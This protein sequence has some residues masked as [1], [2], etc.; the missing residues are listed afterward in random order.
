MQSQGFAYVNSDEVE[1]PILVSSRNLNHAM[2]GDK[3]SVRLFAARKKHDLEGEIIEITE[4]A[5]SVFVGTVQT[6][7]NF[8]F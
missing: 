7:R 8:A 3:V 2:A 5:K 1:R 4:R 6:S